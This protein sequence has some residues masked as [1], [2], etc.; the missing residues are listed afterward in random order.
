M[1]NGYGFEYIQLTRAGDMTEVYSSPAYM[2]E[3][4]NDVYDFDKI[5]ERL[6]FYFERVNS[7]IRQQLESPKLSD[8]QKAT[9]KLLDKSDYLVR[10]TTCQPPGVHVKEVNWS[11][12]ANEFL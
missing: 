11:K 2:R 5:K 6:N 4:C 8:E 1:N 3:D 9:L 10:S 12:K 7:G